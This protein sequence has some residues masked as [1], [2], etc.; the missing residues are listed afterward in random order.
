MGSDQNEDAKKTDS[1]GE[2]SLVSLSFLIASFKLKTCSIPSI[3]ASRCSFC[4]A[5]LTLDHLLATHSAK[6]QTEKRF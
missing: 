5:G 6:I 1:F 2:N 4:T 3:G